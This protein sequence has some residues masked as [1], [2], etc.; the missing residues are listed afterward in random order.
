[1]ADLDR[2]EFIGTL[3]ALL[4]AMDAPPIPIIDTHIHLFDNNRPEG[5]PYPGP[6][7]PSARARCRR[8]I[9]ML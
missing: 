6:N 9:E 1:M 3:A 7:S 2:R 8:A 4:S 5:S